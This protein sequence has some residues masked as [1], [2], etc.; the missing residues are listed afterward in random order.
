MG[1]GKRR[2]DQQRGELFLGGWGWRL[3]GGGKEKAG[4]R[5][6]LEGAGTTVPM[7]GSGACSGSP[8][9]GGKGRLTPPSSPA[10]RH[11]PGRPLPQDERAVSHLAQFLAQ[12][13]PAVTV[14]VVRAPR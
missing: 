8:G 5:H 7:V 14:M 9:R 1:E 10:P 13:T 4:F 6:V 11:L 2:D 12:A 3:A